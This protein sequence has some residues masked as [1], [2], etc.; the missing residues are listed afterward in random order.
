MSIKTNLQELHK[1][2]PAHVKLICVSKFHPESSVMEAYDCGERIFGESRVQELTDKQVNLPADIQWHFIG[3]L[4]T[5]KVKHLVPF[6]HLLHGID[7]VR[8]LNEVN[9]QAV[10][11][12]RKVNCL[13]QM[14]IA[15]EDTK[16]GFDEKEIIEFLNT[17]NP[18]DYSHINI[19]GLMGMATFTDDKELV[20]SEFRFLKQ[21]FDK[22]KT[23]YFPTNSDF[24]EL[25]MG[26]SD[27]FQIAIEEGSTMVRIGTTIFGNRTY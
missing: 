3:H 26:M 5:N 17:M 15:K 1:H 25:S 7:S 9:K 13:L 23:Q 22:V 4:Q 27:D 19:C 16:F 21:M 12:D 11:I 10:R 8:L 20:R 2:I 6:V 14:H 24:K 18:D